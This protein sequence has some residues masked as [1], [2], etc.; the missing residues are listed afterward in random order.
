M[1]KYLKEIETAGIILLAL[2]WS[3]GHFV[4]LYFGA[5][6]VAIGILLWVFTVVVKALDWQHY[7][8]DNLVNIAIIMGAIIGIFIT[9][10]FIVR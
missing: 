10:K 9:L 2:G 5:A 7:R 4:N 8:R 1:K 6:M 3:V